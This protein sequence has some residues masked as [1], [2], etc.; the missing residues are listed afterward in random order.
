ML[1][2]DPCCKDIP[3]VIVTGR[4][5]MSQNLKTALEAGA[6]D[7]IRKPIEGV[8][9]LARINSALTQYEYFMAMVKK[10]KENVQLTKENYNIKIRELVQVSFQIERKNQS[11]AKMIQT[12]DNAMQMLNYSNSELNNFQKEMNGQYTPN[13]DW[14]E[15]IGLFS[16]IDHDFIHRLTMKHANLTQYEQKLCAY[17][18]L[19]LD[20]KQIAK[21][22][23]INTDSAAKSR[24]RLRKKLNLSENE[25]LQTFLINI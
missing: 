10:E 13:E 5:L 20:T 21:I 4:M 14:N 16:E 22:L 25:N 12:F 3:V 19:G 7:F 17:L 2:E 15:F 6:I 1:K 8:E 18:R 24:V 11:I 9:L 23:C